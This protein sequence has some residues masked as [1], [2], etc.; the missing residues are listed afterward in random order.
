MSNVTAFLSYVIITTF[1]PGPNNIMAMSNATRYGFKKSIRFNAGVFFGFLILMVLSSFLSVTLYSLI[2]SIKPVMTFIGA[3]YILW[4][5]WKIYKSK[6]HAED[7]SHATNTFT[8]GILLQFVN[9][10][11]IIYCITIV[12]TFIVPYYD[13]VFVLSIFSLFLASVSFLST[14]SWAVFGFLFQKFLFKNERIV[15]IIM[16]LLLVYTALS[17][18][19]WGGVGMML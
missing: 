12:S 10:K 7:E 3:S 9:V 4:L 8:A 2:P 16:A 6:P 18:Y 19:L 15:N 1:T 14:C 13:S 11:A 5:A 17:F